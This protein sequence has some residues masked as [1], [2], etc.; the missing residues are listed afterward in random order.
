MPPRSTL[1]LIHICSAESARA[2]EAQW[3]PRPSTAQDQ[4]VP[5]STSSAVLLYGAVRLLKWLV[6]RNAPTTRIATNEPPELKT[7]PCNRD[8]K[9]FAT[10]PPQ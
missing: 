9:S 3:P 5:A 7:E 8:P 2:S 6:D 10:E 1:P 4:I